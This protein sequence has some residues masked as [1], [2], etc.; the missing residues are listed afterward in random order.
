MEGERFLPN[1]RLASGNAGPQPESP[2]SRLVARVVPGPAVSPPRD[3]L[4]FQFAGRLPKQSQSCDDTIVIAIDHEFR[5]AMPSRTSIPAAMRSRPISPRKSK[6][7]PPA[8][9]R[10]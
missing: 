4:N 2:E 3:R 5:I 8:T 9:I 10:A 7:R 1:S 6:S